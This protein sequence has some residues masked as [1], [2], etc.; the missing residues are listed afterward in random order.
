MQET[1]DLCRASVNTSSEATTAT[2]VLAAWWPDLANAGQFLFARVSSI[3]GAYQIKPPLKGMQRTE[4][5][6]SRVERG[7]P[8]SVHCIHFKS[9]FILPK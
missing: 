8:S 5:G 7:D 1:E 9:R 2:A 6:L 4:E 3:G